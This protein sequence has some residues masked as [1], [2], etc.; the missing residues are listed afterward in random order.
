MGL[1]ITAYQR[2]TLLT[3]HEPPTDDWCPSE[4]MDGTGHMQAYVDHAAFLPSAAGLEMY[5]GPG[6]EPSP[7]APVRGRCYRLGGRRIDFRAGS[8]G[9]FGRWRS[10]LESVALQLPTDDGRPF[11]LLTY[12]SDCEGWI[13]PKAAAVLANQFEVYGQRV[14]ELF[15]DEGAYGADLYDQWGAAFRLAADHG[16]VRFH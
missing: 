2:A 12:F 5:G 15:T 6:R 1:D 14:K 4:R 8:Y 9:G 10:A 3:D 16:V 7:N 13:G 11:Y